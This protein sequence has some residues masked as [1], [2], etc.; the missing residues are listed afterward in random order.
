MEDRK[1]FLDQAFVKNVTKPLKKNHN[2]CVDIVTDNQTIYTIEYVKETRNWKIEE[3]TLA[4]FC[5]LT[6]KKKINRY[7]DTFDNIRWICIR[8]KVI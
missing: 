2:A 3:N 5:Y 4:G 1:S 6:F 7:I 8:D